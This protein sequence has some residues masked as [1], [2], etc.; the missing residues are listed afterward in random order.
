MA[1][2]HV[3][4]AIALLREAFPQFTGHELKMALYNTARDLGPSG[5]DNDYGM[6]II[7]VHAA[8]LSL[9]VPNPPASFAAYSDYTTPTSIELAWEDPTNLANGDTLNV[10]YYTLYIMRDGDVIDSLEGGVGQYTD[11]GLT[12]GQEYVY[13]MYTILDSSGLA[14]RVVSATWTAGGSAVPM[15]PGGF[16]LSGDQDQVTVRW[17]NPGTNSDGTPMIDYGGVNLYQDGELAATFSR[18]TADTGAVDSAVFSPSVPG[19]YSWYLTALDTDVPVHESEPTET[20]VTPLNIPL[21]DAFSNAGTPNPAVWT[22]FNAD[23]NT[24]SNNPPST[25]LALNMNG[26]PAGGDTLTL[27]PLDLSGYQG[28]GVVLAYYY[29][30]Q[31]NGNA[32]EAGDSLRLQFRNDNGGWIQVRGYAGRTLQPFQQEVIDLATAPNGGG[33]YF[34]SQFQLRFVNRGSAGT[35]PNDDWF[36]DNVFFGVP[37]PAIS[38]SADTVHFDSTLVGSTSTAELMV[39][40]TGLE[41][42]IVSDVVVSDPSVFSVDTTEFTVAPGEGIMVTVTFAPAQPEFYAGTIEILSNDPHNGTLVAGLAGVG[43]ALTSIEVD[44]GLPREFA[45]HPNYPNPFNPATTIKYELPVAGNVELVVYDMLGSRV[46]T[47]VSGLKEAGYH[48]VQ[49]DGANEAGIP[50]TTGVYLYRFSSGDY[51][52]VRKMMLLK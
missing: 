34:H 12:E 32:P 13:E 22:S 36:I 7:D 8:F 5:E 29:Q 33:S 27:R 6:G 19:P 14:S 52:R 40:N 3:V 4:G 16:S 9:G 31:G 15:T 45:V 10:G 48:Q 46:R 42:L 39:F 28:S 50:V 35:L 11:E 18:T 38:A 30:P 17:T 23:V 37:A 41:D 25:P 43:T 1:C 24:R 51:S 2:P 47:L 20:L 44:G 49:W 21:L 26:M